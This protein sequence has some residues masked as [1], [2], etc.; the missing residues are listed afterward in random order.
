MEYSSNYEKARKWYVMTFLVWEILHLL[1]LSD[2]FDVWRIA[3]NML[4]AS[5][6]YLLFI[7]MIQ[8]D[9]KFRIMRKKIFEN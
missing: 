2:V 1:T 6:G 7:S 5:V 9:N 4:G 3:I 8:I